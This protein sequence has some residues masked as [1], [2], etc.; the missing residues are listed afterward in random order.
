MLN[1]KQTWA[2][3]PEA[4]LSTEEENEVVQID[5]DSIPKS[6]P[7]DSDDIVDETEVEVRLS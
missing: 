2:M 6:I 3:G 1:P 7:W 4:T 5:I